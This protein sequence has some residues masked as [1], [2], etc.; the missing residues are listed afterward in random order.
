MSRSYN[1]YLFT[2]TFAYLGP[3]EVAQPWEE[4]L[5]LLD[6]LSSPATTSSTRFSLNSLAA[7]CFHVSITLL[8]TF[9]KVVNLLLTIIPIAI[10]CP[11]Q[12]ALVFKSA[13]QLHASQ[14]HRARAETHITMKSDIIFLL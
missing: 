6:S 13:N 7:E 3:L 4:D 1:I 12:L 11:F 9:T 10:F 14:F 5:H 2:S 8:D